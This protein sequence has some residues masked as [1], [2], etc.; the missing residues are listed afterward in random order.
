MISTF[1][2][3]YIKEGNIKITHFYI[4]LSHL[5]GISPFF[6]I[7]MIPQRCRKRDNKL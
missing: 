2:S 7:I 5:G 6:S 1:A 3:L 4:I